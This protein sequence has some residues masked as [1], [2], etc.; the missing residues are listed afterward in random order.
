LR[1]QPKDQTIFVVDDESII[2]QTL[3]MILRNAGYEARSF[4]E[5]DAALKAA[6]GERPD[7]LLTDMV[8]PEMDGME[9]AMRM[10]ELRPSCKVLVISGH[11]LSLPSAGRLHDED[12]QHIDFLCKPV[13]PLKL[14][15]KIEDV[16]DG[17]LEG[18]C[19]ESP[20]GSH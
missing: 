11:L 1:T 17:C 13:H 15:A 14:L 4:S 19:F 5:P 9:L 3:G 7:L 10:Q 2:S 12:R 18:T 20:V 6:R 8:M 16:L